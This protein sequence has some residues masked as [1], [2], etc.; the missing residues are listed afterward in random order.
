MVQLQ[1]SE[2]S[3]H[4][5]MGSQ[6]DSTPQNGVLHLWGWPGHLRPCSVSLVYLGPG[7]RS[8]YRNRNLRNLNDVRTEA[9]ISSCAGDK[10]DTEPLNFS[11]T[12][13]QLNHH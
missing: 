3:G 13:E 7:L 10:E 1:R 5:W 12:K 8:T 4:I 11:K 2:V 6:E 9:L